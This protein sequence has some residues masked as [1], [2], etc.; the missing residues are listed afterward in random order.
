MKTLKLEN[1]SETLQKRFDL[2]DTAKVKILKSY[3]SKSVTVYKNNDDIN[4]SVP[5]SKGNIYSDNSYGIYALI[6][7][8]R[9]N[10]TAEVDNA[11][12][13]LAD[14]DCVEFEK[15]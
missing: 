12:R 3:R 11:L 5:M 14:M 7:K 13:Q 6:V 8:F 1:V 2:G 10:H 9:E 4:I 15:I